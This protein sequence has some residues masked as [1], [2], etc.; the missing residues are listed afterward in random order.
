M[1]SLYRRPGTGWSGP[2]SLAL[3]GLV[4]LSMLALVVAPRQVTAAADTALRWVVAP[5]SGGDPR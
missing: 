3:F 2:L 4:Y 5:L 1:T